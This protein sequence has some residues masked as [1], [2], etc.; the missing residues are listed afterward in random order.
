MNM[1]SIGTLLAY[2]I[3]CICVLIL[4]YRNEPDG[5]EFVKNQVIDEPETSSGFFKVVEKYFNLSNV[6]NANKETERVATT[7]TV[8][9]S[10]YQ[11]GITRRKSIIF[12]FLIV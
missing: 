5:D 10:M 11:N 6:D 2:T 3:V 8:L 1:M 12:N 4:R 7:I 9:Y